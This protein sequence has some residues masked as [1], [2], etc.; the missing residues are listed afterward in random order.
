MSNDINNEGIEENANRPGRENQDR[1]EENEQTSQ[2]EIKVREEDED[3]RKLFQSQM[4]R[5]MTSTK[6]DT[7][8]RERLMKV[9][10]SD[11]IKQSAN[12]IMTN[13]RS[14]NHKSLMQ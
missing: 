7:E 2:E 9:K 13:Q 14:L 11:E 4:E 10:L 5:V 1:M 8:E 3:M 6:D 12:R